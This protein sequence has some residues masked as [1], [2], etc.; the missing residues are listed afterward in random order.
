MAG[1]A[2]ELQVTRLWLGPMPACA[3]RKSC[4]TFH[5][6]VRLL[7]A[8]RD[9]AAPGDAQHFNMARVCSGALQHYLQ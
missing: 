9:Q 7:A 4:H 6:K 3:G 2:F 1:Y 8:T 5:M